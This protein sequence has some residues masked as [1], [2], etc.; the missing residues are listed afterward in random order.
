MAWQKRE[1]DDWPA[2]CGGWDLMMSKQAQGLQR[3]FA[4]LL[5]SHVDHVPGEEGSTS[6]SVM[7]SKDHAMDF[8]G[9]RDH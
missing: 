8:L 1:A 2:G 9:R 5:P 4:T 7:G 6:G 3:R